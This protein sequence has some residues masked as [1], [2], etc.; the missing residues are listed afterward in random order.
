[1]ASLAITGLTNAGK[2]SL[3]AALTGRTD[4]IAA[5]PFSTTETRVGIVNLAD[6]LLDELGRMEGSRRVT[7]AALETA[8]TPPLVGTGGEID[9]K[10]TGRLRLAD[11]LVVVLRAFTDVAVPGPGGAPV[12]DAEEI[13]LDLAISDADMFQRSLVR[14]QNQAT[15][16]PERRPVY[17]TVR[18]AAR[19]TRD[20]GLLRSVT[21]TQAQRHALA[22]F[23]P[24]TLKPTIWVI[25]SNE[26]RPSETDPDV[27]ATVPRDDPI[28]TMTLGL[29]AEVAALEP[30][31]RAEMRAALGLGR[32]ASASLSGAA[33]S[34]L[35]LCVFYTSNVRETRAWL[36]PIGSSARQAAGK[37][38]SD[39][40]RGFIR[41][42]VAPVRD[43][44][45]AGGWQHAVAKRAVRV[46]GRDYPVQSGDVIKVRFS[47]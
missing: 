45:A 44:T 33:L 26:D 37:V 11:C 13:M 40:E 2:S 25:N 38:H 34:A 20:G 15:S 27:V 32:G 10:T 19:I 47:V 35:G 23:A 29:E 6:P 31:E 22:D 43:V 24:L 8:D 39:M 9:P 42:E 41:A 5:F 30:Q 46:E 18:R 3:F 14:L 17:E 21:W 16:R 1:M 36:T 12:R 7:R 4:G 28:L